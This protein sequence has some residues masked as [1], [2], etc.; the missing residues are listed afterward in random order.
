MPRKVKTQTSE[1]FS[2]FRWVD[3]DQSGIYRLTIGQDPQAH[4]FAVNVPTTVA[5]HKG[6]E[7]DLTRADKIK[8]Q[9]AYP[10]WDLQVVKDLKDIRR[11]GRATEVDPETQELKQPKP[12]GPWIAHALLVLS[13]CLLFVEVVLACYFGHYSAPANA[14]GGAATRLRWLP[15]VLGTSFAVIGLMAL[16]FLGVAVTE[17]AFSGDFLGFC[18]PDN[19][20]ARLEG[21]LDVPP[22]APGESTQWTLKAGPVLQSS[23]LYPMLAAAVLG[24]AVIVIFLT[25]L[26]EARAGLSVFAQ[27]VLGIIAFTNIAV[28]STWLLLQPEIHFERQSWPDVALL[29]DDSLSMN[30]VDPYRD[31]NSRKPIVRLGERYKKYVEDTHPELIKT[32]QAQLEKTVKRQ[33]TGVNDVVLESS[34]PSLARRI[35]GLQAQLAAVRAHD[36]EADTASTGAIHSARVPTRLAHRAQQEKSPQDSHFSSRCHRTGFETD[37]R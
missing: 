9:G 17:Y 35:A 36:V 16:A 28:A 13:L 4:L 7:S 33:G 25:S 12:V 30:G 8:L 34:A 19:L 29:I 23:S 21:L 1:D 5:D 15:G 11:G 32:L 27:L 26:F 2:I 31:D 22:P 3:T 20:R 37:R 10:G 18:T 24:L 14:L 6:S